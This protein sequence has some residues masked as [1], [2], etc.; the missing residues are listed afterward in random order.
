MNK[1]EAPKVSCVQCDS[2]TM[3]GTIEFIAS[4]LVSSQI[5]GNIEAPVCVNKKCPNYGLLQMG[6]EL[7]S[8]CDKDLNPVYKSL[9]TE[10]NDQHE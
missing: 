6:S 8:G 2:E 9:P 3:A 1:D 7:M 4:D 10:K 5:T